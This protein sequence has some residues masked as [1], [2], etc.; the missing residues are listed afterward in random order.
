MNKGD[1]FII[2]SSDDSVGREQFGN[3]PAVVI[4][5]TKTNIVI[6]APFTSNKKALKFQFTLAI[7]PDSQNNLDNESIALIFHIKSIDKS[8]VLKMIGK[9]SEQDKMR[10]DDILREMLNL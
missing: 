6:V 9:I 10:I 2:D 4:S 8:R 3:R 7:S 1:I 5:N